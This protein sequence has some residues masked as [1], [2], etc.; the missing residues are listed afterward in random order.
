MHSWRCAS[1]V[2]ACLHLARVKPRK[3]PPLNTSLLKLAKQMPSHHD[4]TA[5]WPSNMYQAA[6]AASRH[7]RTRQLPS[8]CQYQITD[9][10]VRQ[11]LRTLQIPVK[12]QCRNHTNV[13]QS[14]SLL[15]HVPFRSLSH[16]SPGA[17]GSSPSFSARVGQSLCRQSRAS[18]QSGAPGENTSI[19]AIS[20]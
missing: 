20:P 14:Q 1:L 11:L 15:C 16:K 6:E 8:H 4:L 12:Q 7:I 9:N 19:A 3:F 5:T 10:S 17:A 2:T 18:K 13:S